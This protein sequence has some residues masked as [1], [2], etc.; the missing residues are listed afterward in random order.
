M[1]STAR[2]RTSWRRRSERRKANNAVRPSNFTA[3]DDEAIKAAQRKLEQLAKLHT[4]ATETA[5]KVEPDRVGPFGEYRTSSFISDDVIVPLALNWRTVDEKRQPAVRAYLMAMVE[6]LRL[7]NILLLEAVHRYLAP[8]GT[9]ES[10]LNGPAGGSKNDVCWLRIKTLVAASALLSDPRIDRDALQALAEEDRTVSRGEWSRAFGIELPT[11]SSWP[12][13]A[14]S[15]ARADDNLDGLAI[16]DLLHLLRPH[17][18]P[19]WHSPLGLFT[20]ACCHM[21]EVLTTEG[22]ASLAKYLRKRVAQLEREGHDCGP[23]PIIEVGAGTGRLSHLLNDTGRLARDV[24]ASDATVLKGGAFW[25]ERMDA[26]A[27]IAKHKPLI[28]LCAWMTIGDD[29]TPSWREMGVPEYILIGS[30]LRGGPQH[31]NAPRE[32]VYSLD[33]DHAPYERMPLDDV[34]KHLLGIAD[35]LPAEDS[36][37]CGQGSVCAVAYR[38]PR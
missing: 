18:V 6:L 36:P 12:M 34:S 1:A 31:N 8:R 16:F 3:A 17:V 25:V 13:E 5:A 10:L 20:Q 19:I 7:P 38:R 9:M 37:F 32:Y 27:A 35:A 28:V 2:H 26:S 33:A 21:A 29:W 4:S 22:I 15:R 24:R 23:I 30:R 11:C 14:Q